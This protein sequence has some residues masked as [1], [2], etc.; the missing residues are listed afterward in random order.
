M[1]PELAK[2]KC[3]EAAVGKRTYAECFMKRNDGVESVAVYLKDGEW[4]AKYQRCED[5]LDCLLLTARYIAEALAHG[6]VRV[7][8]DYVAVYER[9]AFALYAFK[10][11][12]HVVLVDRN[13]AEWQD[14][15]GK[16]GMDLSDLEDY[17]CSRY[18]EDVC[19]WVAETLKSAKDSFKEN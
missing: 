3:I 18:D 7:Y 14:Y 10:F 1:E 6:K 11:E 8:D 9:G 13:S 5:L 2:A 19:R 17:V 4:L 12:G 16:I 15:I